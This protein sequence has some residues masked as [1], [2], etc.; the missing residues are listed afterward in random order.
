[1]APSL[2][3]G[4]NATASRNATQVRVTVS[5]TPVRIV[6]WVHLRLSATSVGPVEGFRAP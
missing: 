6:P 4:T 1:V 3:T 2:L 5:G